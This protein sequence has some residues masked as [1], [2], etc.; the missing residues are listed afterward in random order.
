MLQF[1]DLTIEKA[2]ANQGGAMEAETISKNGRSSK[3]HMSRGNIFM[4]KM[5]LLLMLAAVLTANHAQAQPE[6]RFGPR[7]GVNF[8]NKKITYLASGGSLIIS[9]SMKPGFQIG[10]I[11]EVDEGKK[12]VTQ[13]GLLIS[14]Q[15]CIIEHNDMGAIFPNINDATLNLTYLRLP[16]HLGLKKDLGSMTFL[17]FGGAYWGIAVAGKIEDEKIEFGKTGFM[18]RLDLGLNLAPGLQFGNIQAVLEYSFGLWSNEESS[19]TRFTINNG[20]SLNLTYLF[21]N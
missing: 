17:A 5:F 20:F 21:G 16:I 2:V 19:V 7:L 1:S 15:K 11:I 9:T 14:S 10:G 6:Y 8:T 4:G 12:F 13:T 3:S 18:P